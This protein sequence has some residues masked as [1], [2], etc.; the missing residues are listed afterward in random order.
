MNP[1]NVLIS[2]FRYKAWAN[3][4]LYDLVRSVDTTKH[5]DER[6]SCIR[7]LNHIYVVDQ[8]FA[9]HL[10]HTKHAYTATNTK[11]TPTLDELAHACARSDQWY[12]DF[13]S[14][15]RDPMLTESIEF[16]FTDT[17]NARMTREEMLMHVI[18]HGGYHRGA[19]GRILSQIGVAPP[20]DLLTGYLHKAEPERRVRS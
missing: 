14:T 17:S 12:V 19:V 5:A 18:T 8:I 3:E 10:T 6:H 2:L 11:E 1:S 4:E 15:L 13:V 20:R 7:L 9:A 16:V